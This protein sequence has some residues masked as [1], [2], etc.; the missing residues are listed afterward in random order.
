MKIII[1]LFIILLK[2]TKSYYKYT[3]NLTYLNLL[4]TFYHYTGSVSNYRDS[5]GVLLEIEFPK[6]PIVGFY[7]IFDYY[8]STAT[9]C[10]ITVLDHTFEGIY[11]KLAIKLKSKDMFTMTIKLEHKPSK[12]YWHDFYLSYVFGFSYFPFC[13]YQTNN[14]IT[15]FY[16][17]NDGF[18][19]LLNIT[20]FKKDKLHYFYNTFHSINNPSYK[21]FEKQSEVFDFDFSKFDGSL[22]RLDDKLIEFAKKEARYNFLLL[23]YE[24]DKNH[25]NSSNAYGLSI[26]HFAVLYEHEFI[27]FYPIIPSIVFAFLIIAITGLMYFKFQYVKKPKPTQN[28]EIQKELIEK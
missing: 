27:Y 11:N 12:G 23:Y 1:Y 15:A 17:Y 7:F 2:L 20:N 10:I 14:N 6:N 21:L 16:N 9:S 22:E 8:F 13:V 4:S 24:G 3:Q 18:R 5:E 25:T 26:A 28:S 19:L